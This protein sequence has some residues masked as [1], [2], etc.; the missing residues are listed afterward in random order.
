MIKSIGYSRK[1]S[2][3]YNKNKFSAS[4]KKLKQEKISKFLY[5]LKSGFEF[6]FIDEVSIITNIYPNYGYSPKN[7]KF[8]VTAP[9]INHN[10]SMI[11]A[12]GF[13]RIYG[14]QIFDG[15]IK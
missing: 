6:L 15:S 2:R 7:Q 12:I 13:E 1:R 9:K 8:L 11:V 5:L 4:P 10:I 3:V 14:Y